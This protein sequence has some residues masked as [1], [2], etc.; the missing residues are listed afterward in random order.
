MQLKNRNLEI[1]LWIGCLELMRYTITRALKVGISH[2]E[3]FTFIHYVPKSFHGIVYYDPPLIPN[4]HILN[5]LLI[6]LSTFLFGASEFTLRLPNLI[7]HALFLIFSMQWL[8]Q[9]HNKWTWI[10]GFIFLNINVYL[11]DFFSLGRGYGMG[12]SLTFISIYHFFQY[13]KHQKLSS[14]YFAYGTAALAVYANFTF[15]YYYLAL[16]GL[17]N[18]LFLTQKPG[19]V[20]FLKRNIPMLIISAVLTYIIYAPLVNIQAELFGGHGSFW[21]DTLES[22]T[23]SYLYHHNYDWASPL[24]DFIGYLLLGGLLTY[25]VS[26]VVRK[27]VLSPLGISIIL[28]SLVVLTQVVQHHVMGTPYITNRTAII[29]FPL[30]FVFLTC[31]FHELQSFHTIIRYSSQVIFGGIALGVL[32]NSASHFNFR[33]ASEWNYDYTTKG[34]VEY[35]RDHNP[36]KEHIS[37]G[38]SWPLKPSILYYKTIWELEWLQDPSFVDLMDAENDYYIVEFFSNREL[39]NKAPNDSKLIGAYDNRIKFYKAEE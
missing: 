32:M 38:A 29:Y 34:M 21:V 28:L 39:E 25:G 14:N 19:I 22:L 1:V 6:K 8:K 12:V 11:L 36:E 15:L 20:S 26:L 3:A 17:F 30:F 24:A 9:L 16:I 37:I 7:F 27:K 33:E 2:D 5:T 35:V 13:H 10:V 18:I 31:L 4:N 23:W